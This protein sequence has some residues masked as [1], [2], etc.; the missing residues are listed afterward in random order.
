R[1]T[2]RGF[3]T[4]TVTDQRS[5]CDDAARASPPV[6]ATIPAAS[7]RP[8]STTVL[9]TTTRK[10]AGSSIVVAALSVYA[11]GW[12]RAIS[13]DSRDAPG[14]RGPPRARAS[15]ARGDRIRATAPAGRANK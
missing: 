5:P 13:G 4:R 15:P 12:R 14:G 6:I 10:S 1:R 8:S 2:V 11:G 3:E 9:P 7:P